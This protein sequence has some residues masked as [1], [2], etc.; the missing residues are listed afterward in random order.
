MEDD[1]SEIQ[2][3]AAMLYA[4]WREFCVQLQQY[5]ENAGAELEPVTQVGVARKQRN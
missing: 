5:R 2:A 4:S 3:P 1:D